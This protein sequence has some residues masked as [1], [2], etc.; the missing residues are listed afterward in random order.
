MKVGGEKLGE[1]GS[2]HMSPPSN[3]QRVKLVPTPCAVPGMSPSE[4][5][6]LSPL[7][8]PSAGVNTAV[9]HNSSSLLQSSVRAL[10]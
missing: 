8:M 6:S 10:F 7:L 5:R 3:A 9:S 4:S 2:T 1:Q